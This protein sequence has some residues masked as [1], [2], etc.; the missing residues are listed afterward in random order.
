E[1]RSIFS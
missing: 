1:V